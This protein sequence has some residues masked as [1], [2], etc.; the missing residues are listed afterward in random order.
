MTVT[1]ALQHAATMIEVATRVGML[2]CSAGGNHGR[3]CDA[4]PAAT[5]AATQFS[6][7]KAGSV[8]QRGGHDSSCNEARG[9]LRCSA[10]DGGGCCDAAPVVM[11]GST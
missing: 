9:M 8:M 3:S 6:A 4:A 5:C 1:D 2:R 10:G 11:G 7:T